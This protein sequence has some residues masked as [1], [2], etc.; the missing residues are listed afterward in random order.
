MKLSSNKTSA[1]T[2]PAPGAEWMRTML[3]GLTMTVTLAACAPAPLQKSQ[4]S[5]ESSSRIVNGVEIE[6]ADVL[7]KSTVAIA[8]P[9]GNEKVQFCSG[10]LIAKNVVVTAGHCGEFMLG[11]ESSY[12]LF[13][14]SEKASIGVKVA[15]I[16]MHE[17]YNNDSNF[18]YKGEPIGQ[19]WNDLALLLLES[20][21]PAGFVPAEVLSDDALLMDHD[22]VTLAGYGL[23]SGG[24]T[25]TGSGTLRKTDVKV[26][27]SK[28]SEQEFSTDEA[29]TGSCNGDA[30]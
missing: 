17:G 5:E 23:T 22:V 24:F 2:I 11:L 27:A 10:T 8:E 15:R 12:V 7:A 6:M 30:G 20:D 3:I 26:A 25:G 21:A 4:V 9:Q 14:L 16:V 1:Q 29:A 13:G 28:F 18:V 19:N